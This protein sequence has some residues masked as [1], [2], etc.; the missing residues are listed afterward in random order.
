MRRNRGV[1]GAGALRHRP[2]PLP[3]P[4]GTL[5]DRL[6]AAGGEAPKSKGRRLGSISCDD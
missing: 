5:Q 2:G 3:G 6:A 4:G 1:G